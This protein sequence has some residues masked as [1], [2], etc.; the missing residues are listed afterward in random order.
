MMGNLGKNVKSKSLHNY[1][2][3]QNNSTA[4]IANKEKHFIPVA[5][6]GPAEKH[7]SIKKG[8]LEYPFEIDTQ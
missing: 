5:M 8:S 1:V 7:G 2:P 6:Y 3:Q 4:V